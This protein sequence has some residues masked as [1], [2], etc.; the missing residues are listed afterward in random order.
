MLV[1][2]LAQGDDVSLGSLPVD[3]ARVSVVPLIQPR[4]QKKQR[5]CRYIEV[6]DSAEDRFSAT[7]ALREHTKERLTV[8]N[9]PMTYAQ[10]MYFHPH[11]LYKHGKHQIHTSSVGYSSGGDLVLTRE[12]VSE[13]S[14]V[15]MGF[16]RRRAEIDRAICLDPKARRP[17]FEDEKKKKL[18]LNAPRY[19]K[20]PGIRAPR[21]RKERN[22][23]LND[24]FANEYARKIMDKY[25][26][27]QA[28]GEGDSDASP[29]VRP[30]F[31]NLPPFFYKMLDL[32][33]D[34][35]TRILERCGVDMRPFSTHVPKDPDSGEARFQ[36]MNLRLR[37]ELVHALS[38]EFLTRQI[39]DLE[40][41]FAAFIAE[42]NVNKPLVYNFRDGYGRLV[43]HGVAAYYN[44][45]SESQQQPDGS[46]ITVVSWPKRKKHASVPLT[47]PHVSLMNMLRKK[48]GEMPIASAM[49]TP[50]ATPNA[51]AADP[52]LVPP[53]FSLDATPVD[54]A[55]PSGLTP[56]LE[57]GNSTDDGT[58]HVLSVYEPL[59]G[60]S[61]E[62]TTTT[63]TQKKKMRK[64][65]K[66]AQ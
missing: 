21:N 44:L 59:F 27:R 43:C 12:A 46:K 30:A 65:L 56:N 58:P 29:I 55:L 26:E 60:E 22:R 25:R 63:A 17:L 42:E 31:G 45:V 9:G 13:P 57:Q 7:S 20:Y 4:H 50:Q 18:H 2:S 53:V 1:P 19:R 48:R 16:L 47:L 39:D 54:H 10:E 37:S 14:D 49:S 34:A 64:A 8:H 38:S 62:S 32:D 5:S 33:E 24:Y 51:L 66:L 11:E 15:D 6:T 28:K 3:S 35:Q 41:A 40:R 36:G 23:L 61:T 52:D